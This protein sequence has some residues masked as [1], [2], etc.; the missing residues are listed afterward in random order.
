M[1]TL[2]LESCGWRDLA[3]SGAGMWE[4]P[5]HCC[6]LVETRQP[7]DWL[8]WQLQAWET[9]GHLELSGNTDELEQSKLWGTYAGWSGNVPHTGKLFLGINSDVKHGPFNLTFSFLK[10]CASALLISAMTSARPS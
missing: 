9:A 6:E 4:S 8:E 3:S 2:T 1:G 10:R 7:E 5:E